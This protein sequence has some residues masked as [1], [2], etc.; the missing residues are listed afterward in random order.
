MEEI[1]TSSEAA[2]LLKVHLRTIY[3]LANKG[4]IPGNKIGRSWRFIKKDI[5][6][7]VSNGQRKQSKSGESTS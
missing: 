3:R 2:V 5:L 1:I 6:N 7:L 4:A